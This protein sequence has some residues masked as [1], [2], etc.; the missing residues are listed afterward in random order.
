MRRVEGGWSG[1]GLTVSLEFADCP[2]VRT[3]LRVWHVGVRRACVY[4]R[5]TLVALD[6]VF[7]VHA[8][9][10][11]LCADYR[12]RN[13]SG[14]PQLPLPC[15]YQVFRALIMDPVIYSHTPRGRCAHS[16]PLPN[17][18]QGPTLFLSASALMSHSHSTS[19]SSNNF[20]LIIN[21]A[22]N[23]YKKRTKKDLLSHPLATQLQTCNS[24]GD[25]LAVLHQQVQGLDR[26]RSPDDRLT[27]WLD[28]TVNVLYTLSETLGEGASLVSLR[29]NSSDN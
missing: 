26:S 10:R 1:G 12:C 4:V 8:K 3:H 7:V 22:L 18:P 6:N 13:N 28:P 25:I 2:A 20:Q 15:R 5:R 21:D 19:S 24:P 14:T 11:R 29:T 23:S 9:V 27:K 16:S 17:F